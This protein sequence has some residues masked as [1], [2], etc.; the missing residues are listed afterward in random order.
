MP[1]HEWK[2]TSWHIGMNVDTEPAL[3]GFES[4]VANAMHSLA[5]SASTKPA[6][7]IA[8]VRGMIVVLV[9]HCSDAV[10]A[11]GGGGGGGGG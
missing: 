2:Q 1:S 3:A 7:Q 4:S 10:T 11:M 9:Y 8:D 5:M 6:R